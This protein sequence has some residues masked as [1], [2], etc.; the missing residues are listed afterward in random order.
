MDHLRQDVRYALAPALQGPGFT[1]VA[2]LTLGARHRRQQRDLQR[3]ERR[4]AEAAAV[5]GVGAPGRRLPR[6]AK[7]IARSMS[8]PNFIDVDARGDARSRTRRRSRRAAMILTG[9]GEPVRLDGREVSASLFNVLRVRP[10]LGP[11]VQRRRE[12]ARARPTSS[13]CRTGCGSSA[14][15]AT[16]SV[17]GTAIQLD[18]VPTRGRRR[19]AARVFVSGRRARPGCRS[20]TTRTSSPSSAARGT[21]ASVA[22]LKPGVTPRAGRP[23]KSRRSAATSRG[24]IPTPTKASA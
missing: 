7:G 15:A 12:H 5:S 22:R 19:D 11:H 21:C 17:I 16:R 4:A 20:S 3:R 14:S 23:P 1:I 24:S 13:S 18:G 2:V 9:E 10:A 8:G 6:D